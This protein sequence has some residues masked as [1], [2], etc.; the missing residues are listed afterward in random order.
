MNEKQIR[1]I[2]DNLA[3]RTTDEL[4]ATLKKN[5]HNEYSEEGFE[6]IKRILVGRKVQLPMQGQITVGMSEKVDRT[7]NGFFV[8]AVVLFLLAIG[9]NWKGVVLAP[10]VPKLST[11]L[12]IVLGPLFS[13]IWYRISQHKHRAHGLR[14]FLGCVLLGLGSFSIANIGTV[15]AALVAAMRRTPH[16]S[17]EVMVSGVLGCFVLY[18][19]LPLVLSFFLC[20]R[21][22]EKFSAAT[23]GQ[24][25]D[26]QEGDG[27]TNGGKQRHG[28]LTA[29]LVLLAIANSLTAVLY[30]FWGDWINR[31]LPS[32]P[33]W[34]FLVLAVFAIVNLICA[35]ALLRWKKW[36][37]FGF[38]GSS[39]GTFFVNLVIGINILQALFGFAGIGILY[40]VLQM[41]KAKKGWTQLE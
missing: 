14:Y 16:P 20:F 33:G 29:F 26:A 23:S 15:I 19:L 35:I 38:I 10:L 37:F 5:D 18:G 40:W 32:T 25:G 31:S 36:G 2:M 1:D 27:A 6:A 3:S 9:V 34:A 4:H 13:F 8:W 21:L 12:G 7:G 22:N 17:S 24:E 11:A 41:G 39:V 28:C 30:L